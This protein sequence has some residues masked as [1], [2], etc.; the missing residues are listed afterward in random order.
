MERGLSSSPLRGGERGV[1][2]EQLR[3]KER[4]EGAEALNW[5][6]S[7]LGM[8]KLERC[9]TE[10]TKRGVVV[11]RLGRV[12]LARQCTR[13]HVQGPC[14]HVAPEREGGVARESWQGRHGREGLGVSVQHGSGWWSCSCSTTLGRKHATVPRRGAEG[15]EEMDG[16][17]VI[18]KWMG[19]GECR[20]C[21]TIGQLGGAVFPL[22]LAQINGVA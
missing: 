21:P 2:G 11:L 22:L 5:S 7:V 1:G 12:C 20:P 16:G 4:G 6:V 19:E 15:T 17:G 14:E 10:E 13:L 8:L 9:S 18:E 3:S